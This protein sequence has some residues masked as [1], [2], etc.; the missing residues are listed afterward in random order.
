MSAESETRRL[1][2]GGRLEMSQSEQ[3]K[4][5]CKERRQRQRQRLKKREKRRQRQRQEESQRLRQS[6]REKADVEAVTGAEVE[7]KF[8]GKIETTAEAASA[9]NAV[10]VA[11]CL[12][13]HDLA[14]CNSMRVHKE[15]PST[16][17]QNPPNSN[18]N[19]NLNPNPSRKLSAAQ[20]GLLHCATRRWLSWWH[21]A[22]GML[23]VVVAA[24]A[25]ADI[26]HLPHDFIKQNQQQQQAWPGLLLSC[27]PHVRLSCCCCC[28]NLLL[29]LLQFLLL[30][31][32]LL[33]PLQLH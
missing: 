13:G 10:D 3:S 22:W 12:V 4:T 14:E 23:R 30:L 21:A 9:P 6:Q 1:S 24:V 31:L 2:N 28:C 33:L 16:S 27:L 11:T 32:L 8:Q 25:E 17:T 29:I 26:A 15:A 5:E 18:S 20:C 19:S 7:G